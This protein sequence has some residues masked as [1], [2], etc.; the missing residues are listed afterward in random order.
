M[1]PGEYMMARRSVRAVDR[2]DDPTRPT[3]YS[4]RMTLFRSTY[5][6]I[7]EPP[8]NMTL[9]QFMLDDLHTHYTRPERLPNT[10]CMIDED[11]GKQVFFEE[12]RAMF[13]VMRRTLTAFVAD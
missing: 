1:C 9:P 5:T 12:V 3:A 2:S 6:W 7:T 10:P 11:T 4:R 8:S 13:A